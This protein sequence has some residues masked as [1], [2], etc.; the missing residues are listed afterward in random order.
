M[1]IETFGTSVKIS[2]DKKMADYYF[3]KRTS[4]FNIVVHSDIPQLHAVVLHDL[5]YRIGGLAANSEYMLYMYA[6]YTDIIVFQR[7]RTRDYRK[8]FF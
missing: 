7:I 2:W 1:D 3:N 5:E 8:L 4:F 6:G